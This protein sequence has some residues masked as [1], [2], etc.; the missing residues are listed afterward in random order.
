M[1]GKTKKE[2]LKEKEANRTDADHENVTSVT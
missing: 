2:D 1:I